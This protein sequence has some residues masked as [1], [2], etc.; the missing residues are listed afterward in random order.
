MRSG[1][2]E[3]RGEVGV[4]VGVRGED[5]VTEAG[6]Q[7]IQYLLTYLCNFARFGH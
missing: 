5:G 4:G 2:G 3:V 7:D 6:I 1:S